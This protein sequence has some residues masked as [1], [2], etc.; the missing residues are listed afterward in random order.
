MKLEGESACEGA[1]RA[2]GAFSG[3]GGMSFQSADESTARKF[4]AQA[5]KNVAKSL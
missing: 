2:T 4:I 3:A 5:P 1:K